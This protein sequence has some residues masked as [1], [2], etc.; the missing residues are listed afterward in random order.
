[1]CCDEYSSRLSTE[2]KN[3]PGFLPFQ[4]DPVGFIRYPDQLNLIPHE[5]D[6]AYTTFGYEKMITYEIELPPAK[7]K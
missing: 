5:F 4:Q 1:M 2:E 3:T 7:R 6:L